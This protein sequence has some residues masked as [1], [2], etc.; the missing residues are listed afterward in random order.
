[1]GSMAIERG[2]KP[3]LLRN[4]LLGILE[5]A[6]LTFSPSKE[7]AVDV[8]WNIRFRIIEL[9]QRLQMT[10]DGPLLHSLFAGADGALHDGRFG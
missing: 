9:M 6:Q 4:D 3:R 8:I 10:F 1:M 2:L 5:A 7:Y